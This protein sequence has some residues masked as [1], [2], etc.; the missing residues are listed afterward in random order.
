MKLA[1]LRPNP[2]HANLR[3]GQLIVV[4]R[5]LARYTEAH[6]IAPSLSAALDD[7]DALAPK[8]RAR[9]D[10]LAADRCESQPLDLSQL[11]APLPRTYE[12][13]DGSAYLHHVRLVR[14]SRQL[15]VPPSL[16]TDPVAYQGGSSVLLGAHEPILLHD[17]E[18]GLDFEGE[19]ACILGD[20]PQ[21]TSSQEAEPYVRLLMLCNDISYRSFI[22][23]ELTK[24]FGFLRS[25]APSAFGPVAV[26]PDE[27]GESWRGGRLYGRLQVSFNGSLIGNLETGP[28]MHF[29]FFDLIQH[30]TSTRPL[31]AGTILGS[32]TV[33]NES[34]ENGISC[35]SERR[36]MERLAQGDPVTPLM[37][38]GDRIKFEYTNEA[39]E[40]VLGHMD[41]TVVSR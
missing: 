19:L 34:G 20:T 16:Q 29:S 18:W 36:V 2:D 1:S 31:G 23:P 37:K 28:E 4:S 11:L 24:G 22:R 12:W 21:G 38:A 9:S 13:I 14:R 25:K 40:S 10:A 5:D 15:T 17:P 39:G 32:G 41:Q 6:D 27:L 7:W 26:T 8:L 35:L 30:A 33:S 3:D